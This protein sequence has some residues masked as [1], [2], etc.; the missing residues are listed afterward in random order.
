MCIIIIVVVVVVVVVVNVVADRRY[1]LSISLS[2]VYSLL[3]TSFAE[4]DKS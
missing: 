2:P 1:N 4:A 3:Y